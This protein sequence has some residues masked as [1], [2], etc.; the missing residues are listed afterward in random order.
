MIETIYSS[1]PHQNTRA[2]NA[3]LGP[4]IYGNAG[5]NYVDGMNSLVYYD[6]KTG[7]TTTVSPPPNGNLLAEPEQAAID[8]KNNIYYFLTEVFNQEPKA[9][10]SR[11]LTLNFSNK[12]KL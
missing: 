7:A 10:D 2:I 8:Q 11:T 5:F 3:N 9:T 12:M 6:P 1:K 4:G